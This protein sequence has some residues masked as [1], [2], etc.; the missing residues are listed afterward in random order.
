MHQQTSNKSFEL[1][2][3]LCEDNGLHIDE[4]DFIYRAWYGNYDWV[5]AYSKATH[6]IELSTDFLE[7]QFLSF[8]NAENDYDF[9]NKQIKSQITKMKNYLYKQ[10]LKEIKEDFE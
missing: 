10:K 7:G 5:I 8:T 6:R 4:N 9:I 1:F 2:V 3:K